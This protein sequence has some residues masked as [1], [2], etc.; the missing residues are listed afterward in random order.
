MTVTLT[1]VFAAV[2][3]AVIALPVSACGGSPGSVSASS[4]PASTVHNSDDVMFAQHM[5]PHHQ[6]AIDMAG[7][8]PSHTA[9]SPLSE[10]GTHNTTRSTARTRQPTERAAR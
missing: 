9:H 10:G 2:V 8:G 4:A 1:R 7:M 5:I 6:Q 3:A